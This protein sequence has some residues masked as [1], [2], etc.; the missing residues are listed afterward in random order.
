MTAVRVLIDAVSVGAM[1][2]AHEVDL[3]HSLTRYTAQ[4]LV[5]YQ[6]RSLGQ[7]DPNRLERAEIIHVELRPTTRVVVVRCPFAEGHL[8]KRR[9]HEFHVHGWPQGDETPGTRVPHCDRDP[10]RLY[11]LILTPATTRG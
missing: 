7:P 11:E 3:R 5:E 1:D 8:S 10:G 2:D 6:T 4:M 9:G